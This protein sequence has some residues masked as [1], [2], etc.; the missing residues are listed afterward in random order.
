M[1]L[2][3]EFGRPRQEDL[4]E[5]QASLAYILHNEFQASHVP[6][7]ISQENKLNII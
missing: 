3:P 1:L 6:D 5:F 2:I 4:C 7:P